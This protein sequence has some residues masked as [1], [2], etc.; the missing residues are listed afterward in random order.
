MSSSLQAH[1][2]PASDAPIGWASLL[3]ARAGLYRLLAR[4]YLEEVDVAWLG[5]LRE[6]PMFAPALADL[7]ALEDP[8]P[9]LRA[10]YAR[11]FLLN[12]PPYEAVYVDEDMMLNASCTQAVAQSYADLDFQPNP[13][14]AVGAADHIGLELECMAQLLEQAAELVPSSEDRLATQLQIAQRFL[15]DHLASWGPIFG[16]A[17][18]HD[19]RLAFYRT[20]GEFTAE[21]L[22]AELDALTPHAAPLGHEHVGSPPP[23][24]PDLRVFEGEFRDIARYLVTPALAGFYLSREEMFRI[25]GHLQLPLAP[26]E[27]R[28]MLVQ[29]LDQAARYE[30][31]DELLAWLQREAARV[32][33][34][35]RDWE[36]TYPGVAP[37]IE[38]W[39]R[40]A[41]ATA[42]GLAQ[43]RR[44]ASRGV[45]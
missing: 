41:E 22:L 18:A 39:R 36:H 24:N 19:A 42:S 30:V 34:T 6:H 26:V 12:V 20:L 2:S 33:N 10:E 21:F 8:L 32:A 38:H 44:L 45:S 1:P 11:V 17:V 14:R 9:K 43:M 4:L 28:V 27:R 5:L 35:G 29:L 23:A 25:G 16:L 13:I 37:V 7:A 3:F 31:L 15:S 40:R